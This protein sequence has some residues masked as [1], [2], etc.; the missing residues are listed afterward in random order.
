MTTIFEKKAIELENPQPY[1]KIIQAFP[2]I[3]N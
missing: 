2:K 1:S 3:L